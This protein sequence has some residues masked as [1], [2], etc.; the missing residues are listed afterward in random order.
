MRRWFPGENTVF[1]KKIYSWPGKEKKVLHVP[2]AA[3]GNLLL[4]L[5]LPCTVPL[6]AL[7]VSSPQSQETDRCSS[8]FINQLAK[9]KKAKPGLLLPLCQEYCFSY[10]SATVKINTWVFQWP[11]VFFHLVFLIFPFLWSS[12]AVFEP[13]VMQHLPHRR[14]ITAHWDALITAFPNPPGILQ[15][16]FCSSSLTTDLNRSRSNGIKRH[17]YTWG[18]QSSP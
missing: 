2:A 18:S 3:F 12:P 8:T 10:R 4:V 9:V 15:L 6:S 16:E 11:T 7:D 14:A 13:P 5:F 17:P 1:L